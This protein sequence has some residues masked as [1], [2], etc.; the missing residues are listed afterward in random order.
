MAG[1]L[2]RPSMKTVTAIVLHDAFIRI[3]MMSSSKQITLCVG[4]SS[5]PWNDLYT[6]LVF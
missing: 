2:S 1:P 6:A 5:L 4:V 3:Y